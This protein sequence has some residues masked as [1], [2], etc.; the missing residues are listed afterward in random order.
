M[1]ESDDFE[2]GKLYMLPVTLRLPYCLC[3]SAGNV[4]AGEPFLVIKTGCRYENSR[5]VLVCNPRGELG[6]MYPRTDIV[7]YN[8]TG[9]T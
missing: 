1:R 4:Y 6:L 2:V 8:T 3:D 5:M 9:Q 7:P